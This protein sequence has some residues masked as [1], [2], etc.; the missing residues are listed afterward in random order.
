[1]SE[2]LN[3]NT[4]EFFQALHSFYRMMADNNSDLIWAKDLEKRYIFVNKAICNILLSAQSTLEPIGKTEDWFALREKKV[5][6]ENP[7]WHTFSEQCADSD[8]I[9]LSSREEGVFEEFGTVRGKYIVMEVHK[10]PLFND[11]GELIGI[12]GSARVITNEKQAQQELEKSEQNYRNIFNAAIDGIFV[13]DKDSGKI[14]DV[15]R[16]ACEMYG[17]SYDELLEIDVESLSSGKPPYTNKEA[18]HRM[19]QAVTGGPHSFDWHA[20]DK[21]RKLFWVQVQLKFA[22]LGGVERILAV[23][24]NIDAAKKAEQ[25][26]ADQ[27]DLYQELFETSPSGIVIEDARGTILDINKAGLKNF[28]YT[29]EELIGKKIQIFSTKN[30]VSLVEKN[31]KRIISGERLR[32]VLESR[33]KDGKIIYVELNESRIK[34]PNGQYGIL[35]IADDITA[36]KEA[37]DALRES[38]A[39]FKNMFTQNKAVMLLIDPKNKQQIL[40]AN[41]AAEKFY[42]YS[43][44]SLLKMNMGGI[45]LISDE[46][47]G[48]IMK[49]AMKSPTSFFQFKH[50]LKNKEIRDVEIYAS[51]IL[52]SGKP[53]MFTIVHDVTERIKA[54]TERNRLAVLVEQAVESI[55][56]TDVSG[57]IEYVNPAFTYITGWTKEETLGKNP[58]ILKSGR[59]E[60]PFYTEL[61]NT[62]LE[63]KKW[64]NIIINKKK[65]GQIYYEKAV[66][67]PIKNDLGKIIN[68]VGIL[69]DITEEKN[70]EQQVTQLQK[71]EAIGTLSGGIAHD[72]NNILTVINGHAEI[73]LMRIEKESKAHR[74]LVSI[75]SAGKKAEKL[76]T[77]LLAF[78]RKQVH[79]SQVVNLN[80]LIEELQ[81]MVRR[82]ISEN[83]KLVFKLENKKVNIKADSGQI[84]QIIINLIVNA[85]D[86]IN[87]KKKT[88]KKRQIL[89]TTAL[90]TIDESFVRKHPETCPGEYV[91]ISVEDSG[92]G[93]DDVIKDRVFEP[94]FTTKE[95]DKGTGLGLSTVYGI[96][97]QNS[98]CLY[99]ESDPGKGSCFNILWP[100]AGKEEKVKAVNEAEQISG[101]SA[102][103]E[104]ILLVEDDENV[105]SFACE[106][107]REM[108]YKV[109]CAANGMEALKKISSAKVKP[110]L[111]ITDI[112]MPGMDGKELV[113]KMSGR[114]DLKKVLF[115]SGY[116]F[117][118]LV[119][120]GN[121]ETGI[122]FLQ[123]PYS[124]RRLNA[125]IRSILNSRE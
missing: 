7:N 117:D 8:A 48:S 89:L 115:V 39:R 64:Q 40:D 113:N 101:D 73:A 78:S 91:L 109:I 75:L 6:P 42:G 21:E 35:S 120:E 4:T 66:I 125:K 87:A 81:K 67:F 44:K 124:V 58:N 86:A 68:F 23:V 63:G 114:I 9:V 112:V 83:I 52:Q 56:I 2:P 1:M 37:E 80:E 93:M 14:L 29:K 24:R 79:D 94:F 43:R 76:T 15:N 99:V 54:E 116:P 103:S 105:R 57:K 102:G 13:H 5:H 121:L 119:K 60:K 98:G 85:R 49:K 36:R 34:L 74:D 111:M 71:M 59:H 3:E 53:L 77:Q 107:L 46:E 26:L 41:G 95:V 82:L 33:R 19:R 110:D 31:I 104:I 25:V 123:K 16:A 90:K 100:V 38:E 97:K 22:V 108:D 12:A 88:F 17:Y 11:N 50:R 62:I 27:K 51:P 47:R 69:R 106:A 84:E 32:Q 55:I 72:F 18:A 65:D 70:L 28:K 92:V 122:N 10:A 45:N 30:T 61:W 20:R 96:V 118:T